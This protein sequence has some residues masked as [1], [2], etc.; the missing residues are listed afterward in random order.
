MG[1]TRGAELIANER[2]RQID[3]E[4]YDSDHD[5][6][7]ADELAVAAATYALPE[8]KRPHLYDGAPSMWPW[9]PMYWRPTPDRVR[10]LTKAGA[11]IAAAI[12]S[13]LDGQDAV[14]S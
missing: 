8:A 6:G 10:E 11:L 9:D 1:M 12:D 4:G 13:L 2:E 7:H 3:E 14:Q 5:R